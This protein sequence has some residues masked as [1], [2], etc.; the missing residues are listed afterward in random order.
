MDLIFGY[1]QKG[2]AAVEG[3]DVF[4]YVTYE[5][6]VD[7]D[8]IQDPKERLSVEGMIRNFGQ[9]LSQLLK[10]PHPRRLTFD[11]A[12]VKTTKS[13]KPLGV[14][15]FLKVLKPFFVDV[16]TYHNHG[17][18]GAHSVCHSIQWQ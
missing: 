13:G 2:P 7:L 3:L 1:K 4:Y 6:A 8:A 14:F 17:T 12:V 16:E 10:E 11:E 18:L 15:N 9:S 5:G